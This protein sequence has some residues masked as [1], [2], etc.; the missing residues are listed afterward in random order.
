[1]TILE[2]VSGSTG[3]VCKLK[4]SL[5]GLK[6]ASR[7]WYE[8]L[9]TLLLAEEYR[10]ST[11]DYSLFTLQH[12]GDF[13][14]LLVYVDDIIL[15]GT[16]LVEFQRIKNILDNQFKIKDLG[17]LKYFL[18]LEVA[19]SKEGISI[20]QRKYC[21]DL[22]D[23]SGLLGAKPLLHLWILLSNCTKTQVNPLQTGALLEDYYT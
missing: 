4:K 8:K 7:K 19:H 2:G 3:K 20:S 10:Q 18:G 16:S 21:L 6:Q 5:Y 11:A 22:L 1:M 9:T 14:A 15:V 17:I 13:T 23:S 12:G